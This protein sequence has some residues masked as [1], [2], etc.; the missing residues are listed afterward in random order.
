MSESFGTGAPSTQTPASSGSVDTAKHEASELKGTA[1][2]QAKDVAGSVKDEATSVAREV[3]TQAK[4]LFAQTQGELKDQ[5]HTQ[6]QRVSEGL[7]SV[8]DELDSMANDSAQDGVAADLVRQVS[9]RLSGAAN[10]LGDRDPGSVLNDVKQFA[11]AKPGTFILGAVIAG[12]VVGRLTK[13]LASNAADEA[14]ASTSAENAI[15]GV[16]PPTTS[17]PVVAPRI[18][19]SP[20]PAA[21]STPVSAEETPIF[22]QTSPEQAS[23]RPEAGNDR[24]D[25]V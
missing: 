19:V 25:S 1:A 23:Q 18:D 11:R 20:V 10:W 16:T 15:S 6:Q 7:R 17:R 14:K 13:A 22:S 4:D 5:A 12:V 8:S 21:A 2:E 3:K 9:G 24:Y